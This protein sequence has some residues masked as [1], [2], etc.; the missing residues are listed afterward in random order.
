MAKKYTR[1]GQVMLKKDKSGPTVKLGV[2]SKNPQYAQ[3]VDIRVK[4]AQGNVIAG[5]T[6]CFLMVQDPRNRKGITEEQVAQIPEFILN[7]LV[8]VTEE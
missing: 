8:L 3:T 5:G 7:D 2:Y 6:D 1:V 4:D